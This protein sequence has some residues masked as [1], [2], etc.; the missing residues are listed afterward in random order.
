VVGERVETDDQPLELSKRLA[1]VLDEL[2]A[3]V[4]S[5]VVTFFSHAERI[6]LCCSLLLV[7]AE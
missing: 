7:L 3:S 6:A 5:F 4:C 2:S 1:H